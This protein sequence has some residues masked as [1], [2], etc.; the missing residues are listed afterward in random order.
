MGTCECVIYSNCPVGV[1]QDALGRSAL[2]FAA[3]N[4][5]AAALLALLGA[6]ATLGLRDRRSRSVLD[7]AP[8]DSQ[9]KQLLLDR[10]A[11]T[12]GQE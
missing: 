5:A 11:G 12:A 2:M 3:G 10:Y 1:L 6:G 7:Y 9:V 8:E 4:C